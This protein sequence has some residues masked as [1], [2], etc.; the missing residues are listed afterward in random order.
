MAPVA[1]VP[2]AGRAERFGAPKLLV[3]I[4]GDVLLDLTLRAL[5]DAGVDRVVVVAAP[6]ADLG[7]ASLVH[8]PRVSVLINPDP[9]RGMFSS[10]QIGLGA[11]TGDPILVLPA[12]MPFVATTTVTRVLG[13]CVE[14]RCVTVPVWNGRRGH[15]V[16]FPASLRPRI[17]A[18]N[19]TL[20][21]A[22]AAAGSVHEVVVD[23][24]G[25][26][27]DVDVPADLR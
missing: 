7:V 27:R 8:D 4:D 9:S 11:A 24:P 14:H 6:G 26:V 3:R 1:V 18:S 17:L 5:L 21:D 22:L 25:V 19:A 13:A 15:P 20:K 2:A 12:D 16:A 10:I 23:D